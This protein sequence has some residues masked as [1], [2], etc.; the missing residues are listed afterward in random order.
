MKDYLPFNL[1]PEKWFEG[2]PVKSTQIFY[3]VPPHSDFY[4]V[5]TWFFF[6]DLQVW[7]PAFFKLPPWKKLGRSYP[8]KSSDSTL[9][10]SGCRLNGRLY[11]TTGGWMAKLF[12]VFSLYIKKFMPWAISSRLGSILAIGGATYSGLITIWAW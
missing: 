9:E 6:S 10:K 7:N 3:R 1:H 8:K 11:V 12:Q 2:Y 5:L 4:R